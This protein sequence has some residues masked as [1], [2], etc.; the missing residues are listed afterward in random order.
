ML[1]VDDAEQYNIRIKNELGNKVTVG[2]RKNIKWHWTE[3]PKEK[4]KIV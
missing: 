3:K 4:V 1:Q 2:T